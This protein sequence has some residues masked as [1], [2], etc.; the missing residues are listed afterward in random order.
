MVNARN[1]SLAAL[2]SVVTVAVVGVE[3]YNSGVYKVAVNFHGSLGKTVVERAS[4]YAESTEGCGSLGRSTK[5]DTVA[6]IEESSETTELRVELGNGLVFAQIGDEMFGYDRTE[7]GLTEIFAGLVEKPT[8]AGSKTEAPVPTTTTDS[9]GVVTKVESGDF[10]IMIDTTVSG[11]AAQ[12]VDFSEEEQASG[13]S[14]LASRTGSV[15]KAAWWKKWKK[16]R[17]KAFKWKWA[18]AGSCALA[19]AFI[20]VCFFGVGAATIATMGAGAFMLW[21]CTAPMVMPGA[22]GIAINC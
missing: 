2:A 9:N 5:G 8:D 11:A 20:A 10:K 3:Q 13:R 21:A 15:R 16:W 7:T 1:L 4:L 22:M 14:L 18:C 6:C 17:K 12:H 19:I